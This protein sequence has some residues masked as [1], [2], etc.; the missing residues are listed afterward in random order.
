VLRR[1]HSSRRLRSRPALSTPIT[2]TTRAPT[3][4]TTSVS[5]DSNSELPYQATRKIHGPRASTA[6]SHKRRIGND[7]K[8]DTS[9]TMSTFNTKNSTAHTR[10]ESTPSSCSQSPRSGLR[11]RNAISG[12]PT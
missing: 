9:T 3:S 12:R 10:N 7:V 2:T 8:P 5:R 11:V 1:L 4:P 6:V